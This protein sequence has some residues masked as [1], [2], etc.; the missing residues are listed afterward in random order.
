M[1]ISSQM[2]LITGQIKPEHPQLFALEFGKI[3]ENDFGHTLS[4]T[5]I[6]QS[7]LNLVKIYVIIRSQLSSI[8]D[9]I[10]PELSELSALELEKFAIFDFVYHL[11]S[12]DIDQSV[13][14]LATIYLRIRFG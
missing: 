10:R 12:P 14:D 2:S 11:A 13:P 9:L 7:A 4:S 3:A 1:P 8:M 5:N 6:D